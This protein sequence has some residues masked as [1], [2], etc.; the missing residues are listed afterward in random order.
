[1]K[2][3]SERFDFSALPQRDK[4]T[5]PNGARLAIYTVV[6]VEEWDIRKPIVRQ[7]VPA[8]QGVVPVPDVQNWSW[9]EFG[10]RVGFWR[11]LDALK[12]LSEDA[13]KI[14]VA[15]LFPEGTDKGDTEA[16]PKIW[17]DMAGFQAK[18]DKFK[19]D[20]AA[21]LAA[22]PADLDALKVEFGKVAANCGGCHETFR[23]KKS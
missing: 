16:S 7:Y 5:L 12:T 1:M 4:W 11:L 15:A 3:P 20:A 22:A 2:M 14:D 13:Q 19:T 9:H 10:M 18:V 21:A 6:S 23:I 17:E 8:P